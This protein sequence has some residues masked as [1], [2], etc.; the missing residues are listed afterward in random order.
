MVTDSGLATPCTNKGN[1]PSLGPTSLLVGSCHPKLAPLALLIAGALVGWLNAANLLAASSITYV[2]SNY[3]MPRTPQTAVT[4]SF[5]K[6]QAAGD[7]NVVVVGWNDTTAAVSTVTDTSGNSYALAVGPTAFSGYL[8]QS[9]YYAK[10]IVA[11]AAAANVVT[12]TFSPAASYPDIR[13]LEYSGADPNNPVD[14]TAAGSGSSST[15]S[16]ASATTPN[17]TDLIFGANIVETLTTGPGSGFT[18]RLLTSEGDIVED[19]MVTATGSYTATAPLSSSGPWVMQMVAFRAASSVTYVQSNYSTPQTPQSTVTVSFTK[20][21]TAGDLNVVVVGWFDTTAVVNTVTD[22]S[23]NT[24][25]R[26]VGPTTIGSSTWP[27]SQSIYYAKNI[28]AA[29]A[30]ANSVTVTFSPAAAYPD[31][32]VLEYSGADPNNPVDVTAASNGSNTASSSGSATTTNPTDLLFGA[33][34]VDTN[35]TGPGSGF[36]LRL[37]TNYGD[38]AEDETVTAA[39]SYSATAPLGSSGAWVMQ[40]VAFRAV[41]AGYGVSVSPNS[42]S[43]A[44]GNQGTSTI[45][46]KV[47]GGFSSVISLSASGA[48]AGTT[49]SF[50]PSTIT[51]AGSSTMTVTV[52]SSTAGGTYPLTVT[53]NGGGI[54]QSATVSLS[55]SS[56]T[57]GASPASVSFGSVLVGSTSNQSITLSN[58]GSTTVTVSQATATGSG[59]SISGLS[60]PLALAAGQSAPFGVIF[61]PTA[62]GSVSG[63]ISIVSNASGSATTVSLSGTG[64]TLLISASPASTS[65]GNVALGSSSTLPVILT[66]TGTG[67][68]TI[69]QDSVTGTGF[70]ISGPTLPVTLSAG[71]NTDFNV[72]FAPT[73]AGSV[74]GSA[75]IVSNATNSPNNEPLSGTGVHA[76]SLSWTASPST[77]TGYNVYRGGQS[78][79]PYTMLNSSLLSGTTYTDATV[80]AGQTYY[81]VATAENSAGLQ[82]QDSNQVQAVVPS[83]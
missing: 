53:G 75:S 14:V 29:A 42:L 60:L 9:I 26:A 68:V 20:S 83:P 28:A 46:T 22:T 56:T 15:S 63:S 40:M 10:N 47:I 54:E 19:K 48:P 3:S 37:L 32:R 23:G 73:A 13:I 16:S 7:L 69:S 34:T 66:N 64:M 35:T 25:T 76:V 79:G 8:T 50:S 59:F 81:Y 27:I 57:L 31:I 21:Q 44:P 12:V 5:T 77:V 61:A 74:T 67:S 58:T 51:S 65:F 30:G 43:V 39:G 33:N 4:I 1:N 49:V 70:T 52:G 55:V 17:A 18:Q 82:S 80:Q 6:A 72:T 71:Q 45:T 38:S 11:A 41:R 62:A 78:G 24:Y 2:Q 36:T